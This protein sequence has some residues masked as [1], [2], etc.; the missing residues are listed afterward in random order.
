MNDDN[1]KKIRKNIH[2]LFMDTQ[3]KIIEKALNSGFILKGKID[4]THVQYE[5]Q[6]IYLFQKP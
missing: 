1:S 3:N 2:T 4:L 6:N 5:Y